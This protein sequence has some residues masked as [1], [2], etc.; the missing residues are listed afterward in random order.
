[1]LP[2][3]TQATPGSKPFRGAAHNGTPRPTRGQMSLARGASATAPGR[4][5]PQARGRGV[6]H[7]GGAPTVSRGS[8]GRGAV[9]GMR[10]VTPVDNQLM[11]ALAKSGI[12][13]SRQAVKQPA[14]ANNNANMEKLQQTLPRGISIMA[15]SESSTRSNELLKEVE[16]LA[17]NLK[18]EVGKLRREREKEINAKDVKHVVLRAQ[19]KLE[20]IAMKM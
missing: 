8:G 10:P 1:M 13:V 6:A 20:D 5:M 2:T 7:R 18:E 12:S 3:A 9:Q 4:G 16:E 19:R 11:G 15:V 14:A 17:N